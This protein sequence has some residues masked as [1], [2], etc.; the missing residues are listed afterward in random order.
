MEFSQQSLLVNKS[1]GTCPP[2]RC[3]FAHG[4]AGGGRFELGQSKQPGL[5]RREGRLRRPGLKLP[6]GLPHWAR[7]WA[8]GKESPASA[9]S[10]PHFPERPLVITRAGASPN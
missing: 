5:G 8:L 7:M 4:R 1:T 2:Y 6:A 10:T 3:V 9:F